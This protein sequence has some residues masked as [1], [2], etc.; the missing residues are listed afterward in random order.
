MTH[1]DSFIDYWFD[2]IRL[3]RLGPES[4]FFNVGKNKYQTFHRIYIYIYTTIFYH[5]KEFYK[6]FVSLDM[7]K[8]FVSCHGIFFGRTRAT[9]A[10][11]HCQQMSL[12]L[13]SH[14]NRLSTG[15]AHYLFR[16]NSK[17]YEVTLYI[18]VLEQIVIK[19]FPN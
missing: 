15:T 17:K 4:F 12:M 13:W 19:N 7:D 1:V 5:D 18:R 9:I 2:L 6:C 3:V 10:G 8:I 11:T 14:K 16:Y